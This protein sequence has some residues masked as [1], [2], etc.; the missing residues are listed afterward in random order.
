MA[1]QSSLF[2]QSWNQYILY[3]GP[4][5]FHDGNIIVW[6]LLNNERI[7]RTTLNTRIK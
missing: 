7:Y 3:I 6:T 4:R 2:L 5:M 1:P